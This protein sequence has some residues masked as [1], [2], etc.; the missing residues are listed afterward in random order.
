MERRVVVFEDNHASD[1]Y[2][3]TKIRPV[4]F[5]RPGIIPLME[6]IIKCFSDYRPVL[7]CRPELASLVAESTEIPV[8]GLGLKAPG[9]ILF[10]NGAI[11]EPWRVLEA[12]DNHDGDIKILSGTKTAAIRV[13]LAPDDKAFALLDNP[14]QGEYL[15]AI[16]AKCPTIEIENLCYNYLWDLMGDI[17]RAI[18]EDVNMLRNTGSGLFAGSFINARALGTKFPGTH[19]I[20]ENSIYL[21]PDVKVGPTAVLDASAGPIYIESG[22]EIQPHTYLVGPLFVGRETLLV[23]GKITACSIGAVC[24][25]GGEVEESIIQ[26]YTNKYHAGFLGH[27]YVGEW[28]NLGAMTTNS[29]LKNDYTNVK[30]SVNGQNLDSGSLKV[31]S[32]IGDFTKTA[33]GTLLNTG[34]N[35]G[36]SCNILGTG[37]VAEKEIPDFTWYARNIMEYRLDKAL[38]VI[39]KTMSRRKMKLSPALREVLGFVHQGRHK[40]GP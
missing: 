15:S 7:F 23:G 32:F 20:G 30:V 13:T 17:E 10:V 21:A 22:V 29:D 38:N 27:A 36:L 19:F 40:T 28:V 24:R 33:I 26:G 6:K 4:Y 25:I 5:L 18:P 39:E 12:L 11:R 1:F 2:P 35:I 34:I 16:G 3:L 8:N 9:E 31:G 37:L 14:N